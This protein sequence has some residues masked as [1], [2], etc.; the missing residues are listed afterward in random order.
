[1]ITRDPLTQRTTCNLIAE[2]TT[3]PEESQRIVIDHLDEIGRSGDLLRR[4][5]ESALRELLAILPPV[6]SSF[7]QLPSERP[8]DGQVLE[9]AGKLAASPE[10]SERLSVDF[11]LSCHRQGSPLSRMPP[12][13]LEKL[14]S[15]VLGQTDADRESR[16]ESAKRA[17]IRKYQIE[18]LGD[19]RVGLVLPGGRS[20]FDFLKE[21]Q[22]A[23]RDM[24]TYLPVQDTTI[25]RW[26]ADARFRNRLASPYPIAVGIIWERGRE[27]ADDRSSQVNYLRRHGLT[28]ANYEDTAV[29]NAAYY[30]ATG[31][32]LGPARVE[33][34][35]LGYCVGGAGV[36]GGHLTDHPSSETYGFQSTCDHGQPAAVLLRY[37]HTPAPFT[38]LERATFAV[39]WALN[40]IPQ[41]DDMNE[42]YRLDASVR[43]LRKDIEKGRIAS[44]WKKADMAK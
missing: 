18:I 30:L 35:L 21:A 42:G 37:S 11:L 2:L 39:E 29:A 17:I 1:M 14:R 41:G 28:L 20:H 24:F 3:C 9:L 7:P 12:L 43:E 8:S 31:R 15:V 32:M 33:G 10:Q 26:S 19:L 40:W 38:F 36:K 44:F 34:G 5:P 27:I 4:L 6:R 16:L 25:E 13:W 23:F 22:A